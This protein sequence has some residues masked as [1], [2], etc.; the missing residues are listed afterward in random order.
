MPIDV[1]DAQAVYKDAGESVI[2]QTLL[3]KR[4]DQ[5]QELAAVQDLAAN[6]QSVIN[7][8]NVRY[9]DGRLSVT[10]F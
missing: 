2:F 3:L 5:A 6:M 1:R 9:P 7:S 8:M 4:A 10:W